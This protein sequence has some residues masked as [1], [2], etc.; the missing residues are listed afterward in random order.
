MS[1]AARVSTMG[2]GTRGSV[3]VLPALPDSSSTP[4]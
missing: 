4:R 3:P 1:H 2:S